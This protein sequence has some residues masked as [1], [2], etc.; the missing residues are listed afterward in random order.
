MYLRLIR[1]N[2]NQIVP[3]PRLV[4]RDGA[5]LYPLRAKQVLATSA[6]L[7]GGVIGFRFKGLTSLLT[8]LFK[9][10][11]VLVLDLAQFRL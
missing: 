10:L 1:F 7:V 3:K 8:I 6:L 4:R 2:S 5:E 11:N 9:Q